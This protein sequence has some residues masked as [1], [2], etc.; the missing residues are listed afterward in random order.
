[1]T[2]KTAN[3]V[4]WPIKR[5][6]FFLVL[7]G[8]LGTGAA[9][10]SINIP[11]TDLFIEVR[12][13]FGFLGF[14]LIRRLPL[15]LLLPPLLSIAGFH[16]MPHL[17][18]LLG[19]LFYSIPFCFALRVLYRK[20]L[21]KMESTL[22]FG[23]IWFAAVMIGYQIFTHPLVW[24][25]LGILEGSV[26]LPKVMEVY[27]IQP[28]FQESVIVALI[29]ALG[30]M[31]NR[32]YFTLRYRERHLVT[33]LRSIGDGVIV[34]DESGQIELMNPVAEAL[35][36]WK[37]GEG[38]ERQLSEVFRIVNAKTGEKC[39]NPVIK[40]LKEGKVVGLANHT[41]LI[42]RTGEKFQIADSGAPIFDDEGAIKGVVLVFRDVTKDYAIRERIEKELKEKAIL[43]QEV[44]HRVKNNLQI[45]S[46]LL[47]LQSST[48][49]DEKS[50]ALFDDAKRRI[51]SMALVHNQLYQTGNVTEIDFKEYVDQL[52]AE[53]LS[54]TEM[55]R[56]ILIKSEISNIV[57][58]LQIA[59]PLGLML[60]ELITN[61]LKHAFNDSEVGTIRVSFAAEKG[62]DK[63]VLRYEDDGV[64]LPE[65]RVSE[66]SEGL[67]MFLIDSLTEQINGKAEFCNSSV[68]VQYRIIFP[69]PG[70]DM[71]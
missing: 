46:S 49:G 39:E 70:D 50:A 3:D 30:L 33:I 14:V 19:N 68:G 2:N 65:R 59:I 9:Y 64:G 69:L 40:V 45:I 25:Y 6:I 26:R 48:L 67:G 31:I 11:H 1:M 47:S 4:S 36:G 37:S 22:L 29:S 27:S 63:Y 56:K 34:T 16:E 60:N 52:A 58:N 44:H 42:S 28:F 51:F 43:L 71:N 66:K 54:G 10:F 32:M 8:A 24:V 18:A 20:L 53:L 55:G 38:K 23:G 12:W 21:T 7:F 57:L 61:S 15:A 13:L 35:T 41:M 17:A 62:T 5:D